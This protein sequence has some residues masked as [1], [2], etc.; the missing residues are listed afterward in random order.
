MGYLRVLCGLVFVCL[1]NLCEARIFVLPSNWTVVNNSSLPTYSTEQG[2]FRA[3]TDGEGNAIMSEDYRFGFGFINANSSGDFILSIV[4]GVNITSS[5]LGTEIWTANRQRTVAEDAVLSLGSSGD[6]VLEDTDGTVAWNIS[7]GKTQ[8]KAIAMQISGNLQIYNTTNSSLFSSSSLVWQSWDHPTHTL[9][10]GQ[11]LK[12][13]N[14]LV[15]NYSATSASQG[16]YKLVMEPGGMVLYYKSKFYEPYWSLGLSGLDYEGI[17]RPCFYTYSSQNAKA[18]YTGMELQ[19]LY[20]QTIANSSTSCSNG[21]NFLHLEP[22]LNDTQYRFMRLDSD[23]NLRSY[24]VLQT[25]WPGTSNNFSAWVPDFG[26]DQSDKCV[27]PKVCGPYGI[28]MNGQCSCPGS[29]TP[30]NFDQIQNLD[31]TQGCYSRSGEPD[32]NLTSAGQHFLLIDEADYYLNEFF[33]P[34]SNVSTIDNC[35][36]MCSSNCSCTAAFF[37]NSSASCY[38]TTGPLNSMKSMSNQ[39]YKA[40]IKVQ[41]AMPRIFTSA[42]NSFSNGVVAGITVGSAAAA[43]FM[44]LIIFVIIHHMRKSKANRDDICEE[45]DPEEMEEEAFLKTLPGLPPRFTY[46]EL[47]EATDNF[48]KKLGT[49]GFGSVY[50]GILKDNSRVAVK[51]LDGPRQGYKEFRAEVATVG[52]IS[53][54]NLVRLRGFCAYCKKRLLVYELLENGSLDKWL[55]PPRTGSPGSPNSEENSN[56]FLTWEQRH[57]VAIGTARGLAYLH[58][59]CREPIMHLDIKPQNILLDKNFMPKVSDFGMSKLLNEDITQIVT[60]VR[61]TPGY[62]APEWLKHSIATKKCDVYS[63]GMVLLELVSGRRNFDPS[64]SD[65]RLCYFPAWAML[66]ALEGRYLDLADTRLENTV[67]REAVIRMTKVAF[68]CIQDDPNK[69]PWMS[70]ALKM[71]E[72]EWDVPD[73]PLWLLRR[74]PEFLEGY[75]YEPTERGEEDLLLGNEKIYDSIAAVSFTELSGPR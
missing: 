15:S 72:G 49:G 40:Y 56:T 45:L 19:I 74:G 23:G 11:E 3:V 42:S 17:L 31:V 64:A 75:G 37:H 69:R 50:E 8:N 39:T 59:Q 33:Q 41:N 68:W 70:V 55:F 73:A 61:G 57:N 12:T 16:S 71:L 52:S 10:P 20:N 43:L 7:T 62:L 5:D 67:D 36:A 58:E 53:H 28:C 32:C 21:T 47:K 13:G 25:T 54:V 22:A 29:G 14:T 24:R 51:K 6:I 30:D 26:L 9:L 63:F 4:L 46:H 65:P 18:V 2:T 48:S 34:L 44:C 35:R 60:A 1:I 38:L 27:L 66:R